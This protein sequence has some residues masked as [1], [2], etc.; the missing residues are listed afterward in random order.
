M[1]WGG[2]ETLRLSERWTVGEEV[3]GVKSGASA[4]S[5]CMSV[6]ACAGVVGSDPR[7]CGTEVTTTS[8]STAVDCQTCYTVSLAAFALTYLVAHRGLS[9][10]APVLLERVAALLVPA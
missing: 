10:P 5:I 4:E 2:T 1:R 8:S 7:S 9:S 3:S 6:G